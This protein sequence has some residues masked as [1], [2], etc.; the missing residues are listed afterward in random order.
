MCFTFDDEVY[1]DAF[2]LCFND[3]PSW[4]KSVQ[5]RMDA[6]GDVVR[7]EAIVIGVHVMVVC[8]VSFPK[9]THL[10]N[11]PWTVLFG[12]VPRISLHDLP[13]TS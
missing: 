9:A 5:L 10:P 12:T 6:V 2:P 13:S 11:A 8:L 7:R 4:K 1:G 3:K